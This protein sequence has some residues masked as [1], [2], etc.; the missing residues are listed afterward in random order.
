MTGVQVV[1]CGGESAAIE[2]LLRLHRL[3]AEQVEITLVSPTVG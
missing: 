1:T 2:G 3:A